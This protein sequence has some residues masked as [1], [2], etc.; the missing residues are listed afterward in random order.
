MAEVEIRRARDNPF[1]SDRLARIRFRPVGFDWDQV[2][3]RL[4][5]LH[6]RGAIVGAKG[7]GKTTLLAELEPRLQTAGFTVKKL[8]LTED[9]PRFLPG[10][11]SEFSRAL[12]PDDI[13]LLDG[14]E[15]L[16]WVQWWR[17]RIRMRR[18]GGL[19]VTTHRSGRWPTLVHC[20][21]TPALLGQLV[22]DLLGQPPA[23]LFPL[24][25]ELFDKHHGNLREA[26][27]ECYDRWTVFNLLQ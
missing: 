23:Q 19:V 2:M 24:A 1:A 20:R 6:Y 10:L 12:T 22:V 15:Q 17:F 9:E 3:D 21:T 18:A 27:A 26:L 11:I 7:S 5:R 14:M 4:A 16:G 8:L 25:G 13:V